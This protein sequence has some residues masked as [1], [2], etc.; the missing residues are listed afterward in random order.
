MVVM[1]SLFFIIS[2]ISNSA[3]FS[4]FG[5]FLL[6]MH[7][8]IGR[9]G[10]KVHGTGEGETLLYWLVA[11]DYGRTKA[12]FGYIRDFLVRLFG[13][14]AVQATARVDPGHI[15][16]VG[17][18]REFLRVET[19][20]AKD[21]RTL[22]MFAPHGIV[23][24]EAS[25]VAL[26][27]FL[28][29]QERLG[30]KR[31]W[32]VAGGTF[33]TSFGWYPSVFR[34]WKAGLNPDA[35]AFSLPTWSN[36]ALY[37]GGRQ[38]PEILRLER[39][40]SEEFF[41]ERLAGVPVAPRGLVF[42]EFNA[43]LHIDPTV[44]LDENLPVYLWEDP[45]YGSQ[46]AHAVEVVQVVGGQVRVIDEIYEQGLI[47][48]EIIDIAT[49]RPWWKV[50]DKKLVSDPHYKDAHHSMTS[51]AEIWL[52]KAHLTAFG[53]RTRI[54]VGVERLKSFLK[55]EPRTQ[56]ARLV[57]HPRCVGLLSEFGVAANP[58][59]KELHPYK[60]RLDHGNAPV[61][62]TPED[63]YNHGI[64]ALCYG[65]IDRFGVITVESKANFAV[66]RFGKPSSRLNRDEEG[67]KVRQYHHPSLRSSERDLRRKE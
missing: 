64:K 42:P 18:G 33:E 8:D 10:P 25:Q 31:G 23:L 46:S 1:V 57:V 2:S 55:L 4:S 24:C 20:S 48:E 34:A 66:Y 5:K 67:V 27:V 52:K 35:V 53:E 44:E 19:K 7:L 32:L 28:R 12:E 41:L 43:A 14:T 51:V 15:T 60:W 3:A 17:N 39:E 49:A 45:G 16:V 54:M 56:A 9:H 61:G 13:I 22:A 11:E 37:P 38:D 36:T 59:D 58:F 62:E 21:P 6:N 65:L 30:P 50:K 29:T 47:T 40:T 63:R 26:E